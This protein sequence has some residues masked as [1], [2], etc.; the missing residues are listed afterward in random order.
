MICIVILCL[1][2][3]NMRFFLFI[4]SYRLRRNFVVPWEVE[5]FA[6]NRAPGKIELVQLVGLTK[7]ALTNI[8]NKF[9]DLSLVERLYEEQDRRTIRL[10]ITDKELAALDEVQ[11]IGNKI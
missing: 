10:M 5:L 4:H 11:A 1:S 7:G 8:L 2:I 6:K 3:L 9:L